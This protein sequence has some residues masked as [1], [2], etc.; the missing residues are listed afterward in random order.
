MCKCSILNSENIIKEKY[1]DTY[2]KN[3]CLKKL[4]IES[5][6]NLENIILNELNGLNGEQNKRYLNNNIGKYYNLYIIPN[7]YF[8][9]LLILSSVESGD[10]I[11][12]NHKWDW[13]K[14]LSNI[15]INLFLYN[16]FGL[17]YTFSFFEIINEKDFKKEFKKG[18]IEEIHMK[19]LFYKKK[20]KKIIDSNIDDISISSQLN[21]ITEPLSIFTFFGSF[22]FQKNKIQKFSEYSEKCKIGEKYYDNFLQV[23]NNYSNDYPDDIEISIYDNLKQENSNKENNLSTIKEMINEFIDEEESKIGFLALLNQSFLFGKLRTIIVSIYINFN[24]IGR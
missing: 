7:V 13:K 16:I 15:S 1:E 17:I 19:N 10:L 6:Q 12:F 14:F 3:I 20:L 2:I 9:L 23:L 4:I 18:K 22:F 5:L 11:K 21:Q 8:I 24:F